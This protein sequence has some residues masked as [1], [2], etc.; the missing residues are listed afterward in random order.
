LT[1]RILVTGAAG[2]IGS[3]VAQA[4]LDRGHSV[5]TIDNFS[6]GS[7]AN[8]AA[9]AGEV[10]L[11]EG[12]IRSYER[13]HTAARGMD[14]VIHLAA[15]PSVPRSIQDPLTTNAVNVTG[16]LNVALASRDAGVRRVVFASSSSVYGRNEALPKSEDLVPMPI[17][18]YGVSKLAAEQYL[19]GFSAVYG[20]EAAALRYFNVFGPRQDP[21]SQ[22]SGVIPK[23]LTRALVGEPLVVFG[24][25]TQSRDFTYVDNV[26]AATCAAAAVPLGD[27]SLVCNIGC[28]AR[29]TLDDL[30]AAVLRVTGSGSR[31]EYG[32]PRVG[33]V[34]HSYADVARAREELGYDPLVS[35]DEGLGRTLE[36][37]GAGLH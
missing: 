22:Y 3:H 4:L 28:G 5:R 36:W 20:I 14:V 19:M 29:H 9:I 2:F 23:F 27:G 24:D 10:E 6:T 37:L 18:P 34:L 32:P 31:V 7:R 21:S 25:G 26:V 12:D 8:L 33:D 11:I 17:S 1:S 15:L 13:A 16:T 30:A 35:L